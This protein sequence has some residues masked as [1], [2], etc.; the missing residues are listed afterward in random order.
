M[1]STAGDG[2][3]AQVKGTTFDLAGAGFDMALSSATVVEGGPPVTATV[4]TGNGRTFPGLLSL[5]ISWGADVINETDLLQ[6]A[7]VANPQFVSQVDLPP[8]TS[9]ATFQ[10]EAQTSDEVY[11]P[12]TRR[13]L[14][15]GAA[16]AVLA[17]TPLTLMDD[18]PVPVATLSATA[19]TTVMSV[20]ATSTVM[21]VTE[22]EEFDLNVFLSQEV[23]PDFADE[24]VHMTVTG[25]TG[26]LT[27][28][29]PT[30]VMINATTTTVSFETDDDTDHGGART[31]TFT[32]TR[33]PQSI[34]TLGDPSSWT[35]TVLDNDAPPGA[36]RNLAAHAG[37]TKATLA[38]EAPADHG[39][40]AITKF[41]YRQG[42]LNSA[43]PPVLEWGAWTD[44][45]GGDGSSRTVE[46][47]SLTNDTEYTFEVRAVNTNGEGPESNQ[48]MATPASTAVAVTWLLSL[49]SD[50]IREGGSV[51]TATVHITGP[52]FDADQSI[53]LTWDDCHIGEDTDILL[54]EVPCVASAVKGL[55]GAGYSKWIVVP[56]G[57][58]QGSLALTAPPTTSTPLRSFFAYTYDTEVVATLGT[59][60][61]GR[62]PLQWVDAAPKPEL[63]IE[64]FDPTTRVI[65]RGSVEV[66]E[67]EA[68]AARIR[69]SPTTRIGNSNRGVQLTVTDAGGVLQRPLPGREISAL[70]RWLRS[71]RHLQRF[72]LQT[73]DSTATTGARVVTVEHSHYRD[74]DARFYTLAGPALTVSVLD[75]DTTA[76]APQSFK[77][78]P[79][80]GAVVLT[81][82]A[83]A[84]NGAA[85]EKYRY[86]ESTDGGTNYGSWTDIPDSDADTTAYRVMGRTNGT[87]YTYQVQAFNR[88]GGGAESAAATATPMG[89]T[90]GIALAVWP[91]MGPADDLTK[92][93]EGG[94]QLRVTL[95]STNNVTFSKDQTFEVF[96]NDKLVDADNLVRGSATIIVVRAGQTLGSNLVVLAPNDPK[97][98]TVYR[99]DTAARLSVRHGGEE[100]A[101]TPLTLVDNDPKPVVTL[102]PIGS[103][104]V[105]EG[106]RAGFVAELS[107]KISQRV[108]IEAEV[109]DN[110]A[111]S[112]TTLSSVDFGI[113]A[114][115]LSN[116][117]SAVRN[118]DDTAVNGLQTLTVTLTSSHADSAHYD[119][120]EPNAVTMTFQD[121][122]VAPAKP[123]G[124]IAEGG[125][126]QVTLTWDSPTDG[127]DV[128][129]YE[130]RVSDDAVNFGSWTD[131]PGGGAMRSHV[132]RN[133]VI[134]TEYTFELQ[135]MN[136]AGTSG[137]SDQA[138]ATP[139]VG[140]DWFLEVAPGML[141]EGGGAV[142]ATVRF[143]GAEFDSDQ[144]V[145]LEFGGEAIGG[146]VAPGSL[147]EGENGMTYVNIIQGQRR[148]TLALSPARADDALFSPP[149]AFPLAAVH[150]GVTVATTPLALVDDEAPPVVNLLVPKTTV[151][152]GDT[153]EV[154]AVLTGAGFAEETDVVFNTADP[155]G[156]LSTTPVGVFEFTTSETRSATSVLRD[157][158]QHQR[159]RPR[160]GGLHARGQ[161]RGLRARRA[162]VGA[163][164]GARRRLEAGRAG[165]LDGGR[166]RSEQHRAGVG[167][168]HE[169]RGDALRVPPAGGRR[170]L[171][172]VDPDR[173]QRRRRGEPHRL[174][175]DGSDR[176]APRLLAAGRERQRRGPAGGPG[177]GGERRTD[178]DVGGD[179]DGPRRRRQP[180]G[181][182]G[183]GFAHGNGGAS[184]TCPVRA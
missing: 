35:M 86:R 111:G 52:V 12:P 73:E 58:R 119:L 16:G 162:P 135:A 180:A 98:E 165:G 46:V 141:T 54:A 134:G 120:G 166:H 17:E 18:E 32:L 175:R 51:V 13:M 100:V 75:R 36:P 48:A 9:S 140:R 105:P 149:A 114:G 83:P 136:A 182:G 184:T 123:T 71:F 167:R 108:V 88:S 26:A 113:S 70:V 110:P 161:R 91:V 155:A 24:P 4:R 158:G 39:D 147:I 82:T 79:A 56:A 179:V 117:W 6:V 59:T 143:D 132:V 151:T 3:R 42:A 130:Y 37:D 99:P 72:T 65:L 49:D 106:L 94:E 181:A 150:G 44:V 96:W 78:E 163:G 95:R 85:V 126:S 178:M 60:E 101:G 115:L 133:L 125:P 63:S 168:P 20:T 11:R 174:Q 15:I 21:S 2:A 154:E 33:S 152:E 177:A 23:H 74:L 77:A 159:R 27:G 176:R 84:A 103:P 89:A 68:I 144:A 146:T 47:S 1:S 66:V 31:V 69:L 104:L 129:T 142:T 62:A 170:T 80:N 156:A 53:L 97:G 172:G 30:S 92:I 29:V 138:K 41:Q 121:D 122:E 22:G 25:D 14:R 34:Y 171:G 109:A 107:G 118:T 137:A 38:W 102:R 61:I 19:T 90:W 43:D 5:T 169:G 7:G 112:L 93:V 145:V 153:I 116:S 67:G 50:T 40:T 55:E 148:A 76:S 87:A 173:R 64:V 45:P 124:L 139:I 57:K 10:V 164:D 127:A 8:H 183:S 131:V 157:H 81:W 28:T 160:R 128:Q